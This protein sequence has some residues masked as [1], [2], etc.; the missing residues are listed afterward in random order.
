MTICPSLLLTHG[1]DLGKQVRI[2]QADRDALQFHW[3]CK[4]NPEPVWT[5]HLTRALFGLGPWPCL[6]EG[7][8]THHLDISG[9]EQ[10]EGVAEIELGL[11]VDD[12]LTED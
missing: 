5:L 3:I 2:H 1:Q 7:V 10:P 6:L 11:Y 8:I 4:E 9:P 12:L